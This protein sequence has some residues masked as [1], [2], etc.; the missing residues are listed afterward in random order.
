MGKVGHRLLSS[1]T[2]TRVGCWCYWWG[3]EHTPSFL[4]SISF[5]ANVPLLTFIVAGIPL[6]DVIGCLL[7]VSFA[8]RIG[9]RL[10]I[11]WTV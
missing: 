6:G 9:R 2:F 11:I 3:C 10:C 8:Y 1:L 7:V 4:N 5:N